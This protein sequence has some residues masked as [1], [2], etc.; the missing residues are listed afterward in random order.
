MRHYLRL[1]L[2]VPVLA[3]GLAGCTGYA[4]GLSP[5]EQVRPPAQVQ[6]Q[7]P[8]PHVKAG[9]LC[10]P[11]GANA[12]TSRETPMVCSRTAQDPQLRWRQSNPFSDP[13]SSR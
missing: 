10:G 12:A 6:T 1:A 13:A 3:F 7:A 5:E 11:E 8:L 2:L 9:R 4:G